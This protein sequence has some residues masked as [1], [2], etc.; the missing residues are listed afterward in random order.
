MAQTA[1]E[2]RLEYL[3]AIGVGGWADADRVQSRIRYWHDRL[4]LSYI[5][6]ADMTGMS[7]WWVQMHYRGHR[8]DGSPVTKC[9]KRT[10]VAVLKARPVRGGRVPALATRRRLRALAA[11]GYTT[12]FIGDRVG[13]V[14][15]NINRAALATRKN[16]VWVGSDAA[17][18]IEALYLKLEVSSPADYGISAYAQGRA[19]ESARRR[20][21]DPP[22]CWDADTINDPDAIPEYT[23]MCGTEAGYAIHYREKSRQFWAPEF[24]RYVWAC[25]PC[26]E[27]RIKER[28]GG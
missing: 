14:G 22:G 23:G 11:A 4:G 8:K 15:T 20:E 26:R 19:R 17:D 3:R 9:N 5:E 13:I 16:S 27:G 25:K 18:K 2:K 24:Q 7:S 1:H 6:I 12:S 21:W 10:E 28:A